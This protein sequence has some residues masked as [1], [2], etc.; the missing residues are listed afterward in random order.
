M[1]YYKHLCKDVGIDIKIIL[2]LTA[3]FE[4]LNVNKMKLI[5]YEKTLI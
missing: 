4:F 5:N 1:L 3:L 2:N